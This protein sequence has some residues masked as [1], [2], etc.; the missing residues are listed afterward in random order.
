M[1]RSAA[2]AVRAAGPAGR[3]WL[4]LRVLAGFAGLLGGLTLA[5]C[6]A[7]A[8]EADVAIDPGAALFGQGWKSDSHT[9]RGA[10]FFCDT[11]R[12][13]G[14]A[15]LAFVVRPIDGDMLSRV[16][17]LDGARLDEVVRSELLG[18]DKGPK[19]DWTAL[20][21]SMKSATDDVLDLVVKARFGSSD[22]VIF[23]RLKGPIATA[24]ISIARSPSSAAI[25][26][27][28]ARDALKLDT[29]P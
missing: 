4:R 7:A 5:V 20:K 26:L 21:V 28:A 8:A 18:L 10:T 2:T 15:S 3:K 14:P 29:A 1:L 9:G 11:A 12:C 19:S 24:I 17:A 27:A 25:N 16:R 13:N 22:S 23:V 6:V